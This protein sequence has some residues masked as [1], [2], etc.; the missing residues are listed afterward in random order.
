[1]TGLAPQCVIQ[2]VLETIKWRMR[3]LTIK[4][5]AFVDETIKTKNPTE[6]VRRVYNLGG[7]KGTHLEN[8]A[9]SIAS[10]N[11][12]KP[13]ILLEFQKRLAKIDD[14]KIIDKW[15]EW[16]L[17]DKDKRVS[18]EAGKEIMKLKDRYPIGKLRIGALEERDR[19][20]E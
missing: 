2:K 19:V 6:A 8:T 4:Q 17:E 9:R 16:A 1:M 12:T 10:E 14:T 18:L 20:L 15:Y 13:N 7:K 11:L 5:K 3:K